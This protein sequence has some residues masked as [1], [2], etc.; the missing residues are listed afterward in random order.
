MEEIVYH[1]V[2]ENVEML[3][4]FLYLKLWTLAF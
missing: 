3:A 1:R 2:T 4:T